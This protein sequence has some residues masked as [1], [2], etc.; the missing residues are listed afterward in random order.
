MSRTYLKAAAL[1]LPLW[2]SFS[3]AR[4]NAQVGQPPPPQQRC[5]DPLSPLPQ[6]RA[7]KAA[8]IGF[9]LRDSG[10]LEKALAKF[11][12]A[13][14]LY[15]DA[16]DR[17]G[18]A[19]VVEQV[20]SI[21]YSRGQYPEAIRYFKELAE[22]SKL[23]GPPEG[24]ALALRNIASSYVEK[25]GLGQTFVLPDGADE[26]DLEQAVESSNQALGLYRLMS[27]TSDIQEQLGELLQIQGRALLGLGHFDGAEQ[28]FR[29]GARIFDE[30]KNWHQKGLLLH[31]LGVVAES[32]GQERPALEIYQQGL[33]A[34][35]K[36]SDYLGDRQFIYDF[37]NLLDK[38]GQLL[39]R[40]GYAKEAVEV[41]TKELA[42]RGRDSDKEAEKDAASAL[43]AAYMKLGQTEEAR[44]FQPPDLDKQRA[45]LAAQV[46]YEQYMKE[47]R[48][49][50]PNFFRN[51]F[52]GM[53]ERMRQGNNPAGEAYALNLLSMEDIWL[54]E[55][56]EAVSSLKRAIE[57]NVG[58]KNLDA[59][60]TNH[61][62]LAAAYRYAGRYDEALEEFNTTLGIQRSL[63][64]RSGEAMTH[65]FIA[66]VYLFR[67]Q[68]AE[69]LRSIQ[70]AADIRGELNDRR[71]QAQAFDLMGLLFSRLG[72]QA[73]ALRWYEKALRIHRELGELDPA[74]TTLG[75][76]GGVYLALND[77]GK[78]IENLRTALERMRLRD[79]FESQLDYL[80]A[81]AV[82]YQKQGKTEE[83][84]AARREAAALRPRIKD[85]QPTVHL[86]ME[87]GRA[88]Q[89]QGKFEQ[90]LASFREAL[91][92]ASRLG[93]SSEM[94]DLEGAI[95]HALAKLGREEEA[96]AAYEQAISVKEQMRA[97][98]QIEEFK[99]LVAAEAESVYAS[100]IEL[101]VRRKEYREAF[102]LTE[103]AR[104]RTLLD[105]LENAGLD[106]RKGADAQLIAK[107]RALLR[108]IDALSLRL[109]RENAR[110]TPD[111]AAAQALKSGLDEKQREY[112]DLVNRLEQ[113]SP[114]YNSL[115][116]AR[117]LKLNE[118]QRR[119]GK[120]VTLVSY[121]VLPEMTLAFVI[122]R[123]SFEPYTINVKESE[124]AAKI[125]WLRRFTNLRNTQ[126]AALRDLHDLL[127]GPLLQHLKPGLV[128]II[129]HGVLHYL[130]FAALTD[131][132]QYFGDRYT[133]FHLPS[134]SVLP[135]VQRKARPAG[136][137]MLALA[138]S[139]A[140][141]LPELPYADEEARA[142]SS[143]YGGEALTT[144]D[145]DKATFLRSAVD[146]G[147]LHLAAH[148]ELSALSPLFSRVVLAPAADGDRSL[149]V[150]DVYGL[151]LPKASLV[152]LSACET[153]LGAQSR[154]DD[155]V[156]LNRAFIYAGTPTVVA[157]LWTVEDA[158][159]KELMVSFYTHLKRGEGKAEALKSAQ[160]ETRAK[161]PH[162]YYWAGFVLTG[163]PGGVVLFDEALSP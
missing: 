60:A 120:D 67:G 40:L 4:V 20:A 32:R 162:P 68:Y 2:L 45:R 142:V 5:D 106:L 42:L 54:S 137:P 16:G 13:R 121:Y 31:W 94:S 147:I 134:A 75:N 125:N 107:E 150:Q 91:D 136:G 87:E 33:D 70:R 58:L 80:N 65:E 44:K 23:I 105:Q 110:P 57:L 158:A 74:A 145:A 28:D 29:E 140:D 131:G 63:K 38:K 9:K 130:P 96:L 92:I 7:E 34:Y 10:E 56:D 8:H 138:Q 144:P 89:E 81:I 132:G 6:C 1:L 41:F 122:T 99:T 123:D 46:A 160:L 104:A 11:L 161:Y 79:D 151:T 139:R 88:Y 36:V 141:G 3:A 135:F 159:T 12:Q 90:A 156:G 53:A 21:Y 77:Y 97:G 143:I 82:A 93:L 72:N 117:P 17:R 27:Q 37:A 73:V 163:D 66:T 154:G 83:S 30:L 127:I 78:G 52:K 39:L 95:G 129:P 152:V 155:I 76:I 26:S 128:G 100:A 69:A 133:L 51:I 98:G 103:R 102:D 146:K 19:V 71:G 62:N 153:Q 49:R 47:M 157:S 24:A 114:E 85:P 48:D 118:L 14:G 86:L 126:P 113:E 18:E 55:Y 59:Q 25:S 35:E 84:L 124:L 61:H 109:A 148:G 101:R 111:S 116:Q 115:R 43:A 112:A 15:K 119:L 50:D 22:L 149:Y 108:E 64:L